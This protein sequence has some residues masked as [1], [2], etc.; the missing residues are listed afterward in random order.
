M[1]DHLDAID[2]RILDHLQRDASVS[3]QALAARVHLSPAPCL[4]RIRRLEEAGYIERRVAL[5]DHRKL[6]LGVVA[7]AFVTLE[8]QRSLQQFENL[9][10]KRPEIVECERLSG[11]HDYMLKVMVASMEDYSAFLDRHLLR[12]P[13]VRGVN[14]SFGLGSLKRTTVLPLGGRGGASAA[15]GR[16]GA[17][18]T[19]T[20]TTRRVAATAHRA[21]PPARRA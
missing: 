7:Y 5:L 9:V 12:C 1:T 19:T 11:A 21:E 10:L 16:Q 13:H 18:A 15:Q 6:G 14:T 2:L 20:A 3:N 17:P 4:R 8:A